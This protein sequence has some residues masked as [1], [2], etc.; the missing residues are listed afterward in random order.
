MAL[1]LQNRPDYLCVWLGVARAGGVTALINTNLTGQA[2]AH[3]IAIVNAKVAIVGA[4]LLPAYQAAT[5]FIPNPGELWIHSGGP[6]GSRQVD[7]AL[8]NYSDADL[9]SD[10]RTPLTI[11]DRCVFVYTSGTT[12]LPKAANINHYRVMAMA[13]GFSALMDTG[14]ADRMYDCLPMYHSNG[15][16]LA[17][18]G[19]LV[20]GGS[21]VIR[22]RFSARDFWND[23]VRHECTLFFYIGELCR[24]LV[25]S[26]PGAN[27]RRHKIRLV[28]GNGLRPDIWNEFASRF[29]IENIREF[30]AATEGNIAIFN[31]DSRPEPSAAFPN[32]R[33]GALS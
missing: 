33:S 7:E 25:N 1:L 26:P 17:T 32:G 16:I 2:L 31:L 15:G 19:T 12:G 6:E 4:D 3:S 5:P 11:E 21:V 10:E 23:I 22:E 29:G 20:Q 9:A 13:K 28:C 27:D 14:P 18:C 8:A 24:Y 30:Y